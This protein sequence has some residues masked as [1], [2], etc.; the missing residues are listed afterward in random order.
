MDAAGILLRRSLNTTVAHA[1]SLAGKNRTNYKDND[2][3][4]L[5]KNLAASYDTS[6]MSEGTLNEGGALR[7]FT[8]VCRCLDTFGCAWLTFVNNRSCRR[9]HRQVL[10]EAGKPTVKVL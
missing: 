2:E 10:F 7:C 8:R 4:G 9:R 5:K 6:L 3:K 1:A